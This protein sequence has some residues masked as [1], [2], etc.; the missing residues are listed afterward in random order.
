MSLAERRR[1]CYIPADEQAGGSA[2]IMHRRGRNGLLA[3]VS[4]LALVVAGATL[5]LASLP[6]D[7]SS[8]GGGS[9]SV[10]TSAKSVGKHGHYTITL[11]GQL[12]APG[13][14]FLLWIDARKI[15]HGCAALQTEGSYVSAG[16]GGTLVDAL[17]E[18]AGPFAKVEA[19]LSGKP[20]LQ[21]LYCGY[22]RF[23]NQGEW[24]LGAG[25]VVKVR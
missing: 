15:K 22:T 12:P 19:N 4:A 11:S 3:G 14:I 21:Y 18:P 2:K 7:P 10:T 23:I 1:R 13:Q 8:G 16:F 9:I 6:G 20:H 25:T 17:G 5:A 24:E